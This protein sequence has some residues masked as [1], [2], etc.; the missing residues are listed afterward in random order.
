MLPGLPI[1][2]GTPSDISDSGGVGKLYMV[3]LAVPTKVYR[4]VGINYTS[5]FG[6]KTFITLHASEQPTIES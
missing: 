5:P 2:H 4:D 6:A 1:W 3:N